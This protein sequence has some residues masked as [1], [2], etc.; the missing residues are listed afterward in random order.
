[1]HDP[2]FSNVFLLE[3]L[4]SVGYVKSLSLYHYL[5]K[6]FIDKIDIKGSKRISI[7]SVQYF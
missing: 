4:F 5:E 3:N 2:Y 7:V 6:K 1:M